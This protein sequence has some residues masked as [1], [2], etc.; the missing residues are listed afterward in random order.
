MPLAFGRRDLVS[1]TGER[2]RER[3]TYIYIYIYTYTHTRYVRTYT[4]KYICL[5]LFS[6]VCIPQHDIGN[7]SGLRINLA[8]AV[9]FDFDG[10]LT[11]QA[12]SGLPFRAVQNQGSSGWSL[13]PDVIIFT[14]T[15][16]V[17]G[18][19]VCVRSSLP[20]VAW[21]ILKEQPL[22]GEIEAKLLMPRW[23]YGSEVPR[24]AGCSISG[25]QHQVR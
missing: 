16:L 2:E 18:I 23:T 17:I 14:I 5:H 11:T 22:S 19:K 25:A 15:I 10:V 8:R 1:A 3:D 4:Y 24:P 6:D 9:L 7:H 21:C 20:F 13:V 12:E